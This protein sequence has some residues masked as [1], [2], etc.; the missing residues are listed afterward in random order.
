M[1]FL[2]EAL[3]PLALYRQFIVCQFVPDPDKPGKTFKYPLHPLTG[4]K[5]DAHDPAIWT[6]AATAC[7]TATAWGDSYG[8]GFTFTE[9]DPFFFIDVDNCLDASGQWTPIVHE[10]CG[11]LPGAA[12]EISQS[13]RGLHIIGIGVAP[14]H[15]RKKDITNKLFD[16]YTEKRFV[17]LTGTGII[18]NAGTV[19]TSAL[20][21]IT[22]KWLRLEGSADTPQTW[23]T[24]GC[25]GWYCADSDA[26]IIE[27]ALRTSSKLGDIGTIRATFADLWNRDLDRLALAF[28]P[29]GNGVDP[30][31]G[32]AADSAL[33]MQLAFWTGKNCER[34]DRMMRLS[35]L[36]REKWERDDYMTTTI[37]KACAAHA[38][39]VLI[40][41]PLV[42][43]KQTGAIRVAVA[44]TDSGF[45]NVDGL[46]EVFK[47]CI[48][49]QDHHGVLLPNGDIVDQGRFKARF[50]GKSYCMDAMND[51]T[52]TDPWAAFLENQ[53]V[54]FPHVEGTCFRPDM[55]FQTVI[56][57][58]ERDWVNV[59]KEA[60]VDRRVGDVTPFLNLLK[61][62]LP[63]GDDA[64]ILL[65][66]LAAVVQYKGIKFRWAIFLQGTEGNGK[67]LIIK[68][69]RR[70]LGDKY[71]F[72]VKAPMIENGFNGWM[73]NNLLY[74][75]DDIYTLKDRT[76]TMEA[77]KS[78]ITEPEQPVTYKGIDSIQ[79]H[80]CGNWIFTDNHR[81]GMSI[82]EDSRR[83]ATLYCA[84]QNKRT[85][86]ADGLSEAFF[87][88]EF[89]PWLESGG[90]AYITEYLHTV[91]IDPRFNPGGRCQ[92]AP[93]TS[94]TLEAIEDGRTGVEQDLQEWVELQE[95][96]FCGGF[97][98]VVM[99]KRRLDKP[100]SALKIKE[101]LG[102]LGYEVHR[103]LPGGRT[104][105]DVSPDST[106][107]VL[108]VK[109]DTPASELLDPALVAYTY[110]VAQQAAMSRNLQG[111]SK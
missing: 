23:T 91:E 53:A 74:V 72:N 34:I 57:R 45:I 41:K 28:P 38:G 51:K 40:D 50:A 19:H 100:M 30:Y 95:P 79:K 55:P 103:A 27:R 6:D 61:K 76:T 52:T 70:A 75:A 49:V 87:A 37:L 110:S 36:A 71:V 101:T 59:Y 4:S 44:R 63:K 73:E 99:L 96:G 88:D 31:D 60:T 78:L 56:T 26:R 29:D 85:R 46:A 81:D 8:V 43:E 33:A 65:S 94:A 102:R 106:R 11:R 5:H 84:Q 14:T 20:S 104:T 64:V 77:L 92:E 7:R 39:G 1:Q 15:R 98:S 86:A 111:V 22:D 9:Q 82:T 62:L 13:G 25:D 47:G 90:Y 89:I 54:A 105:S 48:Y 24:E 16:L 109:T 12:V 108:Y 107:P 32:S 17:A 3:A 42:A 2:P 83:I 80:I 93:R 10:L 21:A 68:C 35:G 58:G 18:G 69:L 66:Y 97:V 67:S